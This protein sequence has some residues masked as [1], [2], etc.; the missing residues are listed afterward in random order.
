M[1]WLPTILIVIFVAIPVFCAWRGY[2]NGIIRGAC[3]ILAIMIALFCG[4]IVAD[5]YG[6]DFDG[7]L[8]PFINGMVDTAENTVL[9]NPDEAV[10][11]ISDDD[12]DDVY[13]VS[14]AII[15]QM[16]VVENAA[17]M[18]AEEVSDECANVDQT[19]C[20]TIGEKLSGRFSYI[21]VFCVAFAMIAIL[22]S[23]IG[24]VINIS[25]K[26]PI[27]GIAEPVLGAVL[28][29]L[30]GIVIMYAIA[31]FLR[32]MGILIPDELLEGNEFI[33]KLVNENPVANRLG[34]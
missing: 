7:M 30:K 2:K 18:I 3:G 15:R 25:F 10:V 4:N 21:L 11:H 29:V 5:M 34:I 32:Y 23:V 26:I 19:M 22:L 20:D 12:K 27:L 14:Y 9:T 28:G 6:H 8:A 24:N 31:M 16:G 33:F 17:V 1:K 13:T